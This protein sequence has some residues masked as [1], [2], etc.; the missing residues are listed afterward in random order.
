MKPETQFATHYPDGK[1]AMI[2]KVCHQAN[3]AYCTALGD[4]SQPHWD[5]APEW[6]KKSAIN[7]VIFHIKNPFNG[8]QAAHD[9]W[10][11][12]KLKDGWVYGPVKDAELKQHPCIVQYADLPVEQQAKDYI[13]T[14][15][16]KSL[17]H[18]THQF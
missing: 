9:N 2:A 6:Q 11:Q 18:L 10:M 15:I 14:S 17:A 4:F 8:E 13:F 1:I 3:R 7:G 12:E 5:A 16:V